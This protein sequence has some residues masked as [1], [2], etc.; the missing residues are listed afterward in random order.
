MKTIGQ[1]IHKNIYFIM[2]ILDSNGNMIY[3]EDACGFW[4]KREFNSNGDR[5]YYEN[6]GGHIEDD[7]L[8][9]L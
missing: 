4:S 2:K 1:I 8:L 6:S 3:Y 5:I 7:R 9:K